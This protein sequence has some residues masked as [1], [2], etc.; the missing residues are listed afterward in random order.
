VLDGRANLLAE[1]EQPAAFRWRH[2]HPLGEFRAEDF[3]LGLQVLDLPGQFGLAQAG[4]HQDER[5]KKS[6]HGLLHS[7]T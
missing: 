1:F 4:E 5:M 3:V 6:G 2:G 7:V